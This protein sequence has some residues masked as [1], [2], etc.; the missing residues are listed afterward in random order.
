MASRLRFE[1]TTGDHTSHQKWSRS[2]RCSMCTMVA[3]AVSEKIRSIRN[4]SGPCLALLFF[5]FVSFFDH[6]SKPTNSHTP[7][8]KAYI[9]C[10]FLFI[11]WWPVKLI[12]STHCMCVLSNYWAASIGTSSVHCSVS[13]QKR[14]FQRQSVSL[15]VWCN[16]HWKPTYNE[17]A[18]ESNRTF[19]V[20][21]LQQK[22]ALYRIVTG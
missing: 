5:F 15:C 16:D 11:W 7:I 10:H 2:W 12:C 14:Y 1:R 17:K 22:A 9:L 8:E 19:P 4:V 6:S 21:R 18:K 3:S 13:D 20:R